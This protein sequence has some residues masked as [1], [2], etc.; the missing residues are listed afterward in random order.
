MKCLFATT[1]SAI[2]LLTGAAIAQDE[3]PGRQ[4]GEM[5]LDVGQAD[6]FNIPG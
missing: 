4:V 6:L 2:V 3:K 5:M 1:V